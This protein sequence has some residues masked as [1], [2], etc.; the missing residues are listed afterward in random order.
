MLS[1]KTHFK[2]AHI[3]TLL[4]QFKFILELR[5]ALTWLVNKIMAGLNTPHGNPLLTLH[6]T[7][8]QVLNAK[9]LKT[10]C[11]TRL[12]LSD[13]SKLEVQLVD[14]MLTI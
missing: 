4:Y 13:L 2:S 6:D 9:S 3:G 12:N 8:M 1:L 5:Y 7:W 10:V 14:E 11:R